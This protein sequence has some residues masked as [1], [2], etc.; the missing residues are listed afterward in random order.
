[1]T[2]V[3]Q[4]KGPSIERERDEVD[5]LRLNDRDPD[6]FP[7]RAAGELVVAIVRSQVGLAIDLARGVRPA[8]RDEPNTTEKAT[9]NAALWASELLDVPADEIRSRIYDAVIEVAGEPA[10]R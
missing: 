6:L 9:I 4:R 3:N 1:M 2:G 10:K 7:I 5:L 8:H